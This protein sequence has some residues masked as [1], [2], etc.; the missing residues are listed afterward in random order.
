MPACDSGSESCQFN[1]KLSF[2]LEVCIDIIAATESA[3]Q[4][5]DSES[6]AL[7]PGCQ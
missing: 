6:E 7:G 3:G 2:Q 5:S 4:V 1:L